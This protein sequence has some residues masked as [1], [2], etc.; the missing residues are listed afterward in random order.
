M[1]KRGVCVCV[2]QYKLKPDKLLAIYEHTKRE[3]EV[4]EGGEDAP[5]DE[6]ASG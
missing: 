3:L 4:T 6:E 5:A 2:C 1:K